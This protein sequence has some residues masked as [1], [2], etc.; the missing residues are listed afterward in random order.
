MT[1]ATYADGS[2][3]YLENCRIETPLGT[4]RLKILPEITDSKAVNWTSESIPGRASPMVNFGYSEPRVIQAELHF[5]VTKSSDIDENIIYLRRIESLTYPGT[6]DANA[7]YYPPMISKFVCGKI[8]GD[9]GLCVILKSYSVRYPT[10]VAVD[11]ETMLP[12]KFSITTSW[13]VVY[14]CSK[15]PTNNSIAKFGG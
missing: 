10:D 8:L 14:S 12:Y 1:R 5:M 15:L 4:I 3:A 7:P 13:E 11:P 6:G 2:L 9:N